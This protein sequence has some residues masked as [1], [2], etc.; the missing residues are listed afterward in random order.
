MLKK[1]Q[2]YI[3][4][5]LADSTFRNDE[6]LLLHLIM[7]TANS[8]ALMIHLGLALIYSFGSPPFM[9]YFTTGCLIAYVCNYLLL[10]HKKYALSGFLL[11]ASVAVYATVTICITGTSA[12]PILYF[13][14][15]LIMQIVVPYTS[16]WKRG[17]V[18][19]CLWI[20]MGI[21]MYIGFNYQP[22]YDIGAT[23]KPLIIF[24]VNIT[25]AACILELSINNLL[26]RF[27][28]KYHD[29]RIDELESQAYT[30]PLTTLYN[31]RYAEIFFEDLRAQGDEP[32]CVAILDID[33]FKKVN[34]S[35]GHNVGDEVLVAL[36]QL[37]RGNLRKS[38]MV[39]RWGGEEFLLM[40]SGVDPTSAFNI[41]EKVRF[42][43]ENTQLATT[44]PSL[45]ITVT[46]GVAAFDRYDIPES[47][48]A[49]DRK[50]YEGKQSTKNVVVV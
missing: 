7:I 29:N 13:I 9:V 38:D 14:I 15:V 12:M 47:I 24:N 45:H 40:L 22:V 19:G 11:S 20:I 16:A 26:R 10:H 28:S 1:I 27:I 25:F 32:W 17:I 44:G 42:F 4:A 41:L 2:E 30:D 31:R 34:D 8:L 33:D 43:I 37:L 6:E 36:S 3:N 21:C 49:C 35:Y 18:I 39:F 50:L 23:S 5:K 46:I 48:A